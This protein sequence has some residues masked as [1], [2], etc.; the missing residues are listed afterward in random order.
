MLN[1]V[2]LLGVVLLLFELDKSFEEGLLIEVGGFMSDKY[3]SEFFN[4]GE[5]EFAGRDV[6]FD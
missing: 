2:V 3:A 5:L 6:L 1:Y 4:V